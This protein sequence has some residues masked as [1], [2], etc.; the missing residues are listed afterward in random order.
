[1]AE[2]HGAPRTNVVDIAVAI[3]VPHMGASGP[4]DKE[5]FSTHRAEGP[6]RTIDPAWH[7]LASPGKE[8]V[9][10]LKF[11]EPLPRFGDDWV[12]PTLIFI[13]RDDRAKNLLSPFGRILRQ[14]NGGV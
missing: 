13:Q 8:G 12:R 10:S 7:Q 6:R 14:G 5:G 9:A 1:M 4:I 11:F 2:N 3:G